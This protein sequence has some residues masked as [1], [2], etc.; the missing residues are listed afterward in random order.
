MDDMLTPRQKQIAGLVARGMTNK[1]IARM[2]GL[3]VR[4]VEDHVSD[5]ASR[6]PGDSRPRHKLMVWF[7]SVGDGVDEAA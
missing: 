4:T 1:A 6:I 7:F 2:T 5:A 3:S